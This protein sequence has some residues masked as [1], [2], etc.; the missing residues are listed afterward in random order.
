MD[1]RFNRFLKETKA[2]AQK[3]ER[4]EKKAMKAA[5]KEASAEPVKATSPTEPQPP[6]GTANWEEGG[7]WSWSSSQPKEELIEEEDPKSLFE[8][9]RSQGNKKW[10]GQDFPAARAAFNLIHNKLHPEKPMAQGIAILA[11]K[12]TSFDDKRIACLETLRELKTGENSG[13]INL[14][15]DPSNPHDPNAVAIFDV[16]TNRQ[17]GFIPKAKD[18]NLTYAQSIND[19]KFVGG[20]IIDGKI[21]YLKGEENAMLIIATGWQY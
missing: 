15:P 17:L 3:R 10:L 21:S 16:K 8:V 12:G 9:F 1:T 13:E 20:Y 7:L 14:I 5:L 4:A 11:A 19:G 18:V 2:E 6:L